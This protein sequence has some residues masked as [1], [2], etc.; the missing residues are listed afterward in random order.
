MILKLLISLGLF[1][2]STNI[3]NGQS[4][5]TTDSLFAIF[6]TDIDIETTENENYIRFDKDT[7]LSYYTLIENCTVEDLQQ[8]TNDNHPLVR[9]YIFSAL[10]S[11]GLDS[12]TT[13]RLL[14]VHKNDT[15]RFST[16]QPRMDWSVI[17]YMKWVV[18]LKGNNALRNVDYKVRIAHLQARNTEGIYFEGIRH[19]MIPKN[20]LMQLDSLVFR[21]RN[22]TINSFILTID[23]TSYESTS[24]KI[25]SEMKTALANSV[26]GDILILHN[27]KVIDEDSRLR[28]LNAIQ[29][30]I[31]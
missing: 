11:K 8:Y 5:I 4:N 24:N 30:K 17:A 10:I 7:K 21:G 27:I 25:T 3:C 13:Q 28:H 19:N 1:I 31:K 29:L 12:S 15:I 2:W 18:D 23:E 22:M 14:A 9:A 20:N 16:G 6:K 26:N